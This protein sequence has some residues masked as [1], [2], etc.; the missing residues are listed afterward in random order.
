VSLGDRAHQGEK[1]GQYIEIGEEMTGGREEKGGILGG[2][3]RHI[4]R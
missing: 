1:R 4:G 3:R 2:R